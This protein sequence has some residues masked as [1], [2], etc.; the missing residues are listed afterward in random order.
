MMLVIS[1]IGGGTSFIFPLASF[2][3]TSTN[4]FMYSLNEVYK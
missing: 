1:R 2:F 3:S 4:S